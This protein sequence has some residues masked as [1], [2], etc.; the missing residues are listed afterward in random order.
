MLLPYQNYIYLRKVDRPA[1]IALFQKLLH[2]SS[3]QLHAAGRGG[4]HQQRQHHQQQGLRSL[5]QH[6][7]VTNLLW[8][9]LHFQDF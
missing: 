1:R 2:L 5:R 9:A 3:D 6:H 4:H 8:S 7:S